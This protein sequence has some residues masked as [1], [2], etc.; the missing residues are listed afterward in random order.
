[1]PSFNFETGL[2]TFDIGG[3]P[4]KTVTFCPT[5]PEFVRRLF[6][7]VE[8]LESLHSA[9]AELSKDLSF[10]EMEGPNAVLDREIR[11]SIDGLFEDPISDAV[12]GKFSSFR[13]IDGAPFWAIFL[14]M[15]LAECAD[16]TIEQRDKVS[17][18][19]QKIMEKYRK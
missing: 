7:V 10:R 9:H 17:P 11:T 2:K 1:M 15:V 14:L 16:N 19:L 6:I 5:D 3:D 18:K 13:I 12:F 4:E 8:D